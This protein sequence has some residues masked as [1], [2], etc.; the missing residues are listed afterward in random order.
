LQQQRRRRGRQ[1]DLKLKLT[2]AARPFLHKESG[3]VYFWGK[4]ARLFEG[5]FKDEHCN[6]PTLHV[7]GPLSPLPNCNPSDVLTPDLLRLQP[8]FSKLKAKSVACGMGFAM[9]VTGAW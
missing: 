1:G 7:R 3:E 6:V 8:A 9:I 2:L 4:C 5:N